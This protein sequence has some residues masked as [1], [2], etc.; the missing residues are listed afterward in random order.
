MSRRAAV[1]G[2]VVALVVALG[3][4][5]GDAAPESEMVSNPRLDGQPTRGEPGT[6]ATTPAPSSSSTTTASAPSNR[7][8]VDAVV[9]V[10]APA[11]VDALLTF[12]RAHAESVNSGYTTPELEDVTTAG[13]LARQ[14]KVVSWAASQGYAVPDRPRVA[15][16]DVGKAGAGQTR[17]DVCLWLPSTEFVSRVSGIPVDESVPATWRPASATLTR[18]NDGWRV[19][20]LTDADRQHQIDCG[21]LT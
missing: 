19:A 5:G 21:G 17:L 13:Q 18:H 11:Q 6:G 12:V 3:G 20:R 9:R 10:D 4:C 2:L 16:V 7:V 8:A 14:A 1:P 15:V